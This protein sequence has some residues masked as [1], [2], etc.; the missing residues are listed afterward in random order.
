[1]KAILLVLIDHRQFHRC[2]VNC[3][4]W[5]KYTGLQVTK[6]WVLNKIVVE[7]KIILSEEF[8]WKENDIQIRKA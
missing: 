2:E 6:M 5:N 4:M 8:T 7:A 3:D 1:M